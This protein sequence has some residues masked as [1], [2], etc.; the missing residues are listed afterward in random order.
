MMVDST[1]AGHDLSWLRL[2]DKV[3]GSVSGNHEVK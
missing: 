1:D 2:S 3:L